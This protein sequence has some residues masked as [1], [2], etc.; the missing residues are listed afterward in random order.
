MQRK[1]ILVLFTAAGSALCWWPS[2][3]WPSIHSVFLGLLPLAFVG[4]LTGVS[5]ARS[6]GPWFRFV[7]ASSAGTLI[8]IFA[9]SIFWPNPDGIAQ[10][11]MMFADLAATLATALV[12]LVVCLTVR[13]FIR[14]REKQGETNGG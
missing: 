4:L 5:T 11:Y 10:S 13:F 2:I 7:A 9:G 8:G 6:G 12:S 1:E 14:L 3:I